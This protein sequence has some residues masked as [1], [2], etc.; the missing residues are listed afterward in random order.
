MILTSTRAITD[1]MHM[2]IIYDSIND[3]E[4]ILEFANMEDI[5]IQLIADKYKDMSLL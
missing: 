3:L 1:T 5:G 4:K 2:M